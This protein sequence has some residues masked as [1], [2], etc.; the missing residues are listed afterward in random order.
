MFDGTYYKI[1]GKVD[2]DGNV[3]AMCVICEKPKKGNVKSTTNFHRHY[4]SNHEKKAIELK[5]HTQPKRKK[6]TGSQPKITEAIKLIPNQD[7]SNY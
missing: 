4:R 7:V 5:S 6:I 3:T 1:Q 2:G